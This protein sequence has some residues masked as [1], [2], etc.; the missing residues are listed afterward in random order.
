MKK[1]IF[2]F[3]L[4]GI[5]AFVFAMPMLGC[6]YETN[7][8]HSEKSFSFILASSASEIRIGEE[9]EFT[10]TFKNLSGRNLRIAFQGQ[11]FFDVSGSGSVWK[12][13]TRI[14]SPFQLQ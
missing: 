6:Q 10:A 8:Q 1:Q 4:V 3:I 7:Y 11:N 14:D 5:L 9:I 2:R 12:K 13:C